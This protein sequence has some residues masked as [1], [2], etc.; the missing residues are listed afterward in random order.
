[1]DSPSFRAAALHFNEQVD[2][3]EKW[4]DNLLK[5]ATKLPNEAS[6]L[7]TLV[8]SFVASIT[9]PSSLSE[10][11]LD[12]DYSLPAAKRLSE[13]VKEFWGANVAELR[14]LD[15]VVTD[16]LRTFLQADLR[17][18]KEVRRQLEQS[19]KTFDQLQMRYSAQA[20][21]KEPS[22][23]REDA[24]QLHESR[25]AYLKAS[26]DFSTSAPQLRNTLD[27][28][29]TRLSFDQ[30]QSLRLS[31]EGSSS[32]LARY[33]SELEKI[34]GRSKEIEGG[35]RAFRR[36]LSTARKQIE[37]AAEQ[38]SRPSRELEDYAQSA[39][40]SLTS[41]GPST[42]AALRPNV[43]N[44][45]KQGWL[46]AKV[47]TG[48]PARTAWIRRWFYVK[49]GVFG[50]LGIGS[51]SGGVEESERIGVLLC[52]LRPASS[53]ERRF[54]FE[55]KTKDAT[56]VLQ[57]DSNNDLTEWMAAFDIAKQKALDDPSSS[58]QIPVLSAKQNLDLAFSISPPS[59]PEFAMN[60]GDAAPASEDNHDKNISLSL[61]LPS[62]GNELGHRGSF[63]VSPG[64]RSTAIEGDFNRDQTGKLAGKLDLRKS[65]TGSQTIVQGSSTQ[66][67]TASSAAGGISSLISASHMALPLAPSTISQ[68]SSLETNPRNN[69]VS[70]RSN[71]SSILKSL[72]SSTLAPLT[73]VNPP[74]A[75][76]L[77][78]LA[79]SVN[80]EKGVGS[81][82]LDDTGST[83]SGPLANLWGSLNWSYNNRLERQN[84]ASSTAVVANKSA[85]PGSKANDDLGES[86]A[87]K[88][89]D[90][91]F[92][93]SHRKTISLDG[94]V[95]GV[96]RALIA[97][98]EIPNFYPMLLKH[99]DVQFRLLFPSKGSEDKV[100]LVFRA[101]WS[102]TDQQE[103]PGRIFVTP[104]D[105][106]FY[107]HHVGLVL[108]TGI[109]L[110][111]VSE[112]T[113]APGRE[114]DFL[115][116]H[117]KDAQQ[118]DHTRITIKTILEPLK[119][120]QK[121]LD[122]LVQNANSSEPQ[123]LEGI[124]KT[125]AR[126]E[127]AD[128][129]GEMSPSIDSWDEST[130]TTPG[131]A[132]DGAQRA[133]R[134]LRTR[135]LVDQDLQGLRRGSEKDLA[136]FKLPSKPV[137]YVPVG[138]TTPA[139]QRE[140]DI[141]PKALFHLLFGDRSA[142][143]QL[144]YHEWHATNVRQGPW[145]RQ[146]QSYFRR[147]IEYS[148]DL[149]GSSRDVHLTDT[150]DTQTIDVN[151]DHLCYVVSARRSPWRL[152]YSKDFNLLSKIVITH[153]AKSKCKL[154]VYN[155]VDWI[156]EPFLVGAMVERQASAD[157]DLDSFDLFDVVTQQVNR[158]GASNT[159]KAIYIFGGI[160]QITQSLKFEG[161]DRSSTPKGHNPVEVYTARRLA[162]GFC[163]SLMVNFFSSALRSVSQMTNR[164]Q[165]ML[166]M[167]RIIVS[168]LAV[169]LLCNGLHLSQTSAAW[170][171]EKRAGHYMRSLG[172]GRNL[173][174]HKAVY[175][176]DL[177]LASLQ[178]SPQTTDTNDLWL[179]KAAPFCCQNMGIL[180]HAALQPSEI[181]RFREDL[182]S[183]S[184][185]LRSAY[186]E[187]D[188]K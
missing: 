91:R 148:V 27:K 164:A 22:S 119:L 12:H 44:G 111:N 26:M 139:I 153:V 33:A 47:I 9:P 158:L 113:A 167:N 181:N 66:T 172:I 138:M 152:P 173:E 160:G 104:H 141:S 179:V 121:R 59:A 146:D 19:Q 94:E 92:D 128:D 132:R 159:K 145:T 14:K 171:R 108:T 178:P 135:V 57:A 166:S 103:F 62:E 162:V 7:E 86:T 21:T 120:L 17:N 98:T 124:M 38:A 2:A 149:G 110:Q 8:N 60:G 50:W 39:T 118:T 93:P 188:I 65:T 88:D 97:P 5:T 67:P 142:V 72:P 125:L 161:G 15:A 169:S 61:G 70:A 80:Y 25:R 150:L 180:I 77:S 13:A 74:N 55:V 84:L 117:L 58:A 63:D 24:F 185:I 163:W 154:A 75:T 187:H 175:L 42:F 30:A 53:E 51:R 143:W 109:N 41:K 52:G 137:N 96:Q 4:L 79:V 69:R 68:P 182:P 89:I 176:A 122:F 54:C 40:V 136:R 147:E 35:E 134:D 157:L 102:P 165:R 48:K 183:L 140:F 20:K 36:E 28:L 31:R 23:L 11:I 184:L 34:R 10:S 90:P 129:D 83:P 186:V 18:F 1:M 56:I 32:L 130:H 116:L 105:I 131:L 73:L 115:F 177:D 170:W 106:H 127:L 123:T 101:T 82:Q 43:L 46:N 99:H 37:E 6:T 100:V 133:G 87:F 144:L 156:K 71:S 151:S 174:I 85:E 49:N 64:R 16:P 3:V 29:L 81:G 155:K 168:I 126:L 95:A 114:F 78:A 45:G 112:V 76:N 107:S